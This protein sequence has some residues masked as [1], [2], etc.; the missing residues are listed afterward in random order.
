MLEGQGSPL[1]SRPA[2]NPQH[3][4]T[5]LHQTLGRSVSAAQTHTKSP[6][7]A[8]LGCLWPPLRSSQSWGRAETSRHLSKMFWGFCSE[9]GEAGMF[10]KH[11]PS[12]P[13]LNCQK[14]ETCTCR[15]RRSPK[16]I[17]AFNHHSL[18][19]G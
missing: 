1:Q 2:L 9:K 19:A 4:P 17:G 11:P 14:S 13:V 7:S 16:G 10:R 5:K 8:S 3:S 18:E 6:G 15:R 12:P